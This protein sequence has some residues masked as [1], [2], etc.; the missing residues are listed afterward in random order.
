M[1]KKS[2][3]SS[4]LVLVLLVLGVAVYA[5]PLTPASGAAAS[6]ACTSQT[7]P[8]SVTGA[9]WGTAA[10]PV[11]AYPGDQDVPL[12]IT[13]LFS[14]P[15]TS[16]QA[17]FELSLA[18]SLY[19]V[20][21]TGPGG[22]SQPKDI[23]LNIVPNTLVT[24]TF[25]LNVDQ[26]AATGL[27]YYIP[28]SIQYA[29]N[30]V[31]SIIT[32]AAEPNGQ[33]LTVPIAL[34]GPAQ[35]NFGASTSHLLAGAV[36]NVTISISNSGSAASGP[37]STT[38]TAPSTVTL[39]NALPT[40]AALPPG[41]SSTA[42][43]QLFVPSSLSGTAFTLTLTSKYLDAYSNSQTA[44]GTLGFMVTTPTVQ[45]SS[46]FVVEGAQWGSAASTTSPLPGTQDTPLV[47]S[48][49]YLAST[50]VTSLQGT[51]K[52][53]TGVTDLNGGSTATAF[54]SA[55][56][57]QYGAIQLTFYLNLASTVKPG[58]Y[59][60][61]LAMVWMT[62]QSIG[63]SQTAVLTPPP[64]AALQS[65]FQAEGTTWGT[66]ATASAPLP[67]TLNNPLVVSLQ[68]LGTTSVTS[69]EGTLTL[70]TGITDL[71]GHQTATAYAATV[72]P[73]AVV[74][75]TFDLDVASSVKPGSY[76]FTLD[77]SWITS[78]SSTL[79]QR[80]TL[81]PPPI[82]TPASTIV[83]P[84]AVAQQNSTVV[85]GSQ[86]G[87]GFTLTNQGTASIF[88]PTFTL[89]LG[90]PLVIASM[91][92]AIPVSQLDPGKITTFA[93]HITAGPTSTAGIYSGTLTVAFTDSTGASHTQA[94]P[95]SFT[96]EGTVILVLQNTAVSQTST[97]FT[98]TGSILNEGSVPAY[99][100]SLTGLLGLN[101]GTPVYIGEIDPNT[102]LPFSVTIPF[103][104]P[105]TLATPN[106]T[107]SIS[108]TSTTTN[109]S[110]TAITSRTFTGPF[111]FSGSFT[112]NGSVI[113]GFPGG[114]GGRGAAAGANGSSVNLVLSLN[115]M[116]SFDNNL[117]HAFTVPTTLKTASQLAVGG[118]TRVTTAVSSGPDLTTYIAYGVLAAICVV[119]VA[120]A[121]LLRRYRAKRLAN[122]PLL[123]S[124][125]KSVI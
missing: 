90:S 122:M 38:V 125:E 106:S 101:V 72:S 110:R 23:G 15:C 111:S 109:T 2:V 83:F 73:N 6:T 31:S 16:P 79:T 120:G 55:T 77:L 53:P 50:P 20:P 68:Y 76:N 97:G 81:S 29:N 43:L 48:L 49:Q 124:G 102:P 65:Q 26:S 118:G 64:I 14:G 9:I 3:A 45:A 8:F 30:T 119:L 71:N 17:T 32:Q 94:F 59:N 52:L 107:T 34:Y 89:E 80:T 66:S 46:S 117:A 63:L 47:V 82:A 5:V 100:A 7:N 54:S 18:A 4:A 22:N 123:E 24:E 10:A 84:L 105:T 33:L 51:I 35:L 42:V 93:A 40:T 108:S 88:S 57:N 98:V 113:S 121:V 112:R 99:Y 104:A 115:Y 103:V 28:L 60:F 78:V 85:A 116:D 39:L 11:S 114:F 74:T 96:L 12:T 69:L 1:D 92:S 58:S 70:P 87:A 75:L 27:T 61:T 56:T 13:M 19:P 25:Y 37:V 86:T 21:F 91:G 41:G 44:T 67:G 62:S 36:D 95:I